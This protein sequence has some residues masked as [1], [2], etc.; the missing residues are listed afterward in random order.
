[1]FQAVREALRAASSDAFRVVHFSVQSDHLHLIV[2]A[3]DSPSLIKGARGL[4]IR[5]ARAINRALGRSGP[6]WGD[7]YHA[8]ALKTPRE[9]RNGLVYVVM[10]FRKHTPWDRRLLD[11]CSSAAW[12]DG[13]VPR[14]P[15]PRE[16]PPVRAARTWLGSTGWRRHGLIRCSERPSSG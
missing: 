11:P 8:R 10:N 13:L 6:V 4:V 3:A 2:E 16:P 12:F 9:V 7:R 5:A 15:L 14:P 1:V